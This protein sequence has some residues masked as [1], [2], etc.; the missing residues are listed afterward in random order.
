MG[1]D[2]VD[3]SV[4]TLERTGS[5]SKGRGNKVTDNQ[6][7]V[8]RNERDMRDDIVRHCLSY[9]FIGLISIDF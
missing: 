9:L 5:H 7:T 2:S 1:S 3:S 6:T 8:D 4:T